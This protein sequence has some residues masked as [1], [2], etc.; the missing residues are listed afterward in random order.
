MAKCRNLW[1][2]SNDISTLPPPEV[3]EYEELEKSSW[4]IIAKSMKMKHDPEKQKMVVTAVLQEILDF[5][6]NDY[7]IKISIKSRENVVRGSKHRVARCAKL[8]VTVQ[9]THESSQ[10]DQI[11]VRDYRP[12]MD[13]FDK[14]EMRYTLKGSLTLK[15]PKVAEAKGELGRE[16][17]LPEY[18]Q[19]KGGQAIGKDD[20]VSW[21]MSENG[22]NHRGIADCDV[23]LV[24]NTLSPE[25][26]L[27]VDIN[28]L[29]V[30]N[31]WY[32][33][34]WHK[35]HG[36]FNGKLRINLKDKLMIALQERDVK[37]TEFLSTCT[38]DSPFGKNS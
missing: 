26:D 24:I 31:M 6:N 32:L 29:Y 13:S 36:H 4:M 19:V 33:P 16:L 17:V 9:C 28:A 1:L 5:G 30:A 8:D 25:V 11:K 37:Q 27:I 15:A 22:V 3:W 34:D 10:S 18:G 35:S 7:G 20:T 23:G 38:V 2:S 14:S 12:T 21:S